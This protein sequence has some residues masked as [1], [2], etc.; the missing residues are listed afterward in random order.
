MN[1]G[2]VHNGLFLRKQ[3]R[4]SCTSLWKVG[5]TTWT[6]VPFEYTA[7]ISVLQNTSLPDWDLG[8]AV[9]NLS[10]R[11]EMGR[12]IVLSESPAGTEECRNITG[13]PITKS[14][15]SKGTGTVTL[16]LRKCRLWFYFYH[17]CPLINHQPQ[18]F[19]LPYLVW[20][21]PPWFVHSTSCWGVGTEKGYW[22]Q[23]P[24]WQSVRIARYITL[25]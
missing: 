19:S 24:W 5:D 1:A 18:Q 8:I 13:H 25:G 21:I 4:K 20:K 10:H 3:R 15:I 14:L 12:F 11:K 23:L 9:E 17:T 2:V 22:C 16:Q 7:I 6:E